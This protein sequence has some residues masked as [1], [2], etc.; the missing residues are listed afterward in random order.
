MPVLLYISR[1]HRLFQGFSENCEKFWGTRGLPACNP[2]HI[3]LN[4]APPVGSL[5]G[6]YPRRGVV[7]PEDAGNRTVFSRTKIRRGEEPWGPATAVLCS[8]S[9]SM[10]GSNS[11]PRGDGGWGDP[12]RRYCR[13]PAN[14]RCHRPARCLPCA[15]KASCRRGC[16]ASGACSR[17]G[18]GGPL[19]R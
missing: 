15:R 4:C 14:C 3:T 6:N 2:D 13:L 18:Q 10:C 19:R 11:D 16:R 1:I 7:E 8:R 5:P 9:K 12:F 17:Y